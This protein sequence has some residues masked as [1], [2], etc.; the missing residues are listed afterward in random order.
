MTEQDLPWSSR[1]KQLTQ[2]S[3]LEGLAKAAKRPAL[4][5]A[6]SP[7]CG[8]SADAQK[9]ID[10]ILAEGTK[11]RNVYRYNAVPYDSTEAAQKAHDTF[12]EAFEGVRL[13]HYPMIFGFTGDQVFKGQASFQIYEYE[14]PITKHGLEKF[15]EALKSS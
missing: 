8:Y 9:K 3:E 6:Y 10:A 15:Y 2:L 7:E 14:G 1:V 11:L 5:V 12:N 4:L 13:R